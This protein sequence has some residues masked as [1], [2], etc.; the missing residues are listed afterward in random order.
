LSGDSVQTVSLLI[1]TAALVLSVFQTYQM[2]RQ[3]LSM[4]SSLRDSVT[5]NAM[6]SHTEHRIAF[7][8]NDEA[9]LAW[10]LSSRGYLSTSNMENKQR[11]YALVKLDEQESRFLQFTGGAMSQEVWDIW[12]SVLDTD[13]TID[14]FIDVWPNGKRFYHREFQGLVDQILAVRSPSPPVVS[15]LTGGGQAVGGSGQ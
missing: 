3:T 7:F 1:V 13:L 10:H 9:L 15:T 12:R 8:L 14:A 11:L 4:R 6:L 5:T 2:R